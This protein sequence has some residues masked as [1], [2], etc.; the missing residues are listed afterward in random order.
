MKEGDEDD[1]PAYVVE[2]TQD[3]LSKEEYTALLDGRDAKA[4]FEVKASSPNTNAQ[5]CSDL[6]D[7]KEAPAGLSL[8]QRDVAIGASKKRRLPKV[9]GEEN[10]QTSSMEGI[11]SDAKMAKGKKSKRVKLSFDDDEGP[12]K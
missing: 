12:A 6:G 9:V 1:Q 4:G 7:V 8:K 11:N 10:M 3:T 2:D 5:S